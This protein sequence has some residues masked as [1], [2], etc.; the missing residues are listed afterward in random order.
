MLGHPPRRVDQAAKLSDL[1]GDL[2][3][4]YIFRIIGVSADHVANPCRPLHC[5]ATARAAVMSGDG[6]V[7]RTGMLA[8]ASAAR[9]GSI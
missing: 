1:L 5:A 9:I 2:A 3:L 6:R 4:G 8:W 7:V